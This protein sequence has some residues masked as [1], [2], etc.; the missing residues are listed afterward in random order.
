MVGCHAGPRGGFCSGMT[1]PNED[2]WFADI[3][4][5]ELAAIRQYVRRRVPPDEVDDIVAEVF[6]AA[7]KHR[8]RLPEPPRFW[9]LRTAWF[10]I[11]K[12]HRHR[13]RQT[14]LAGR[15]ATIRDEP[16]PGPEDTAIGG[17]DVRAALARLSAADREVLRLTAWEDLSTAQ[18]AEVLACTQIAA[19]TRLH[20]ARRKLARLLE[21]PPA[22]YTAT[23]SVPTGG[24]QG[25]HS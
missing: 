12:Q 18:L 20:R 24:Q 14:R 19:R 21:E 8:K 23:E 6:A 16:A 5:T 17:A 15:L 13:H 2:G 10:H 3:V 11:S 25:A 7:W 1:D 9:L 4:R 22:H